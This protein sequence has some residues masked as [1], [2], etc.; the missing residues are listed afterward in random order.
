[1]VTEALTLLKQAFRQKV[2]RQKHKFPPGLIPLYQ[3]DSFH[4][5]G[6]H[7]EVEPAAMFILHFQ[8]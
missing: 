5:C 1:M 6:T 8:R 7:S 2:L 3:P 4:N